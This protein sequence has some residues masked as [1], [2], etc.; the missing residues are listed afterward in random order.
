[1][2]GAIWSITWGNPYTEPP[3]GR[4]RVVAERFYPVGHANLRQCPPELKALTTP[5]DG[6]KLVW[7]AVSQPVVKQPK[8]RLALTRQK[9][10]R[11]RME[12]KYPLLA[13]WMIEQDMAKRPSYYAG[14]TDE[15]IEL[16]RDMAEDRERQRLTRL[17]AE[18]EQREGALKR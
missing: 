4:V 9:R 14:E 18:Y 7:A 3:A 12:K 6:Y 1:M 16:A 11:R 17:L 8:D 5:G 15:A 13:E 10:L 2:I